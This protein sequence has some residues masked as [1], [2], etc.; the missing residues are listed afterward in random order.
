MNKI[1]QN[2]NFNRYSTYDVSLIKDHVNRFSSEWFIDTSRQNDYQI[3]K[4]T[5]SYFIYKTDLNWTKG[6]DFLVET[7]TNDSALLELVEPIIKDLESIHNGVRGNVLLIKLKAKH[8]IPKHADSGDYL[9]LSRRHHIAIVTSD[10]TFFG[11]GSEKVNMGVG[12][13]WE[14]NNTRFHSVENNSEIDRIHLLIDIMPKSEI[15]R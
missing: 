6:Q 15:G 13:C 12:E 5:T 7:K 11:V 1:E 8:N 9:V 10:E 4:D 2:F 14:I 3:H